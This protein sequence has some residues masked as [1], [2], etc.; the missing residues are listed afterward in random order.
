MLGIVFTL[1]SSTLF[2]VTTVLL[3]RGTV[4]GSAGQGLVIT[5]IGGVPLF[6]IAALV[7]GQLFSTGDI[8]GRGYAALTAAGVIHFLIGRYCTFRAY[9]AI[10]ANRSSPV[11]QGTALLSVLFALT[12]LDEAMTPLK[13]VGIGLIFIGPAL[14]ASSPQPRRAP[15]GAS[16]DAEA[17]ARLL[18]GY[19][20]AALGTLM[21]GVSPILIR[22]ALEDSGGLGVLGGLVSYAAAAAIL[23][24]IALFSGQASGALNL[25]RG[26]QVWFLSGG[27][28]IFLGHMFRFL[29]LSLAPVTIVIPL[30]RSQTIFALA[31]GY[32]VNRRYESFHPRTLAGVAA[33]VAGSLA[34]V[35]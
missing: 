30:L 2:G 8:T 27:L 29:A 14:A 3:R 26:T 18:E 12:F 24:P 21:F 1:I 10:G 19:G 16:E 11:L 15:A 25:D 32:V 28:T 34:L 4:A 33:A 35:A 5:V 23:A 17:P 20:F 22:F 31:L 7:S 6:L 9:A 13:A